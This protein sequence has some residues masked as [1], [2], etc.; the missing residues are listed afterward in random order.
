MYN[1]TKNTID[2]S[3]KLEDDEYYYIYVIFDD[4]NGKYAPIEHCLTLS[5]ASVYDGGEHWYLFPYGDD[6]FNW[7]EFSTEN[8]GGD[9][10]PTGTD[11]VIPTTKDGTTQTSDKSTSTT[12]L[13][14]TGISY[15]LIVAISIIGV[16]GIIAYFKNNKYK[17]I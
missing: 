13:P 14:H 5:E 15:S 8:T 3:G 7:K 1:S 4:E 16:V 17:G 10:T 11:G 2:L 6:K 12:I 9:Y